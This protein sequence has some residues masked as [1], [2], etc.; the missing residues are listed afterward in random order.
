MQ[1]IVLVKDEQNKSARYLIMLLGLIYRIGVDQFI[2]KVLLM[3]E[4]WFF[5]LLRQF[6]KTLIYT[7]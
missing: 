1:S 2:R 4:F 5:E 3:R 7:F 6:L